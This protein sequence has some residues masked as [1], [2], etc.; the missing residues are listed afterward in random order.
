[1]FELHPRLAADTL[2]I[3]RWDL[4][5]LRLMNDARYP[6][7]ILVPTR[8]NIREIHHLGE[9]DQITLWD[10]IR[11]ATKALE[12]TTSAHKMNIGALGNLVPQ[13]HIH[14]IARFESDAAWPGPVWGV[15]EALPYDKESAKKRI[16]E[17][18]QCAT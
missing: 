6:W 12:T 15:G 9:A 16:A 18:L 5:D 13:L 1:M 7:I 11:R 8:D 4:C 10:D 17:F 14:I 2:E 3:A